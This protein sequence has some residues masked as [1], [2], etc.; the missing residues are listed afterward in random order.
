VKE[1]RQAGRQVRLFHDGGGE[2]IL[3]IHASLR[4]FSILRLSWRKFFA[5]GNPATIFA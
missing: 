1:G 4:A 3:I 2:K 5:L